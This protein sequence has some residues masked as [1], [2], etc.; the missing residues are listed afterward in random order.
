MKV[1]GISGFENSIPFKRAHWPG[2]EEREYRISQGHDSAAVLVVDGEIVAAAAE[3][4][5]S[6]KKHTG[7]F[8]I[9]AIEYCLAEAGIE[10]EDID[11]MAHG[12]DYS[13][14]KEM[15]SLDPITAEQYSQVFSREALLQQLRQALPEFPQERFHAVNH[16]LSHAASAY[17]TSG[18]DECLVVV[19][20]GM[21]EAHSA[22]VYH[23]HDNQLDKLQEISANDSIGILYSVIT[24][25][26][27][28]DFNSDEYKIMGLAPYGNPARYRAFFEEAVQCLDDGRIQIPLLKINKSREDRETYGATRRS[29]EEHLIPHRAPE[30][31]ITDMHRDVA[32]ALQECLDRVLLHICG[33]FGR[34]IGLRRLAMA[35]GVALNCTANGKL[36]RSGIFDD[37]YVQPAAGD[38]GSALGAALW[39]ASRVDKIRN[40][41]MPVPFL[42]PA[43][44][45]N[46]I[47][48]ALKHFQDRVTTVRFSNLRETCAEAARL[49]HDGHVIA[50]YRGRMEFGPRALG[51]R[52]IL[53]DPGHPEMRDRINAM[54]KMREAFRPF[55]PAVSSEQVQDWFEVSPGAKFPYMVMTVDV[56][57]QHRAALPA[58]THVNGSA[59]VQTVP[60]ADNGEFHTLLEE[61]GKTT[62]RQMVLNTSFNVKGQ[63]IVNTPGEA[64][65][66]F[67]RTGIEYLFLEDTLVYRW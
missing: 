54:V 2:L 36:L 23:A 32:A 1:L 12:F 5:F 15:Y 7:D 14:Y 59:R 34:V 35:G 38:D 3:E 33:H 26:L 63:P 62:G 55:A 51:H 8:P 21:G 6:R 52:S 30:D 28:F 11:E 17:Y 9:R 60:R 47:D 45:S 57:P 65:E 39:R 37:I 22:T 25:H 64:L 53:A 41:R 67:L 18:W 61:V 10:A 20:D 50:W 66:T 29:L 40:V 44:S 46:D 31:E 16:H 58:I 43:A 56:Q 13:P 24:L 42:G 48:E 49:I 27:G 19:I 4:R